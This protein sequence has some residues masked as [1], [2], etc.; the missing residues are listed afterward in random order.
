MWALP[1]PHSVL[2]G[3][4]SQAAPESA[5]EGEALL[6]TLVSIFLYFYLC[7]SLLLSFKCVCAQSCSTLFD[8]MNYSPPGSSVH[9]I[10]QA[11]ILESD[12]IFSSRG[13]SEP[14]DQ[15]H[16]SY[17]SHIS[18]WVLYQLYHLAQ[19]LSVLANVKHLHTHTHTHTHQIIISVASVDR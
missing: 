10:F 14:S 18:R 5:M 1:V 6:Y 3:L 16:V 13:S 15:T 19:F 7:R 8:L 4:H 11:R 9:G 17:A 12:A 2:E